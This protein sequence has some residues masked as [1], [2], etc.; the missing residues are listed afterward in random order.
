MPLKDRLIQIANAVLPQGAQIA[1][2][3]GDQVALRESAGATI[4]ADEENWRPLSERP[5][6]DLTPM[7]QYRMQRTAVY[8]WEQNLLGNRLVELPLAYMLA[9][10]VKLQ[11][12][13]PENQKLLDS[14]WNDPINDMDL[15]LA[16]KVRELTLFGEQCYPAFVND[17]D[18]FVRIGYLDPQLI[19][20]V[21][22]DPDNPEQPIGI[23]TMRNRKGVSRR[24][25]VIINGPEEVFTQ[26]TQA[27][28]DTFADGEAFYF[29]INDLS[30]GT[31]GRSDLLAQADWLD[32]YDQFLFGEMDRQK[33]LRAFIWDVTLK[34]ADAGQV[35]ARAAEITAPS[36]NSV[37]VHNDSE[38]WSAEAPSLNAGDTS[39]AARLLRNHVLG[40][41][42]MPETWYGGGG[43][44]N[45]ATAGEMN[46][47]TFKIYTMRQTTLKN[48]LVSI[49]RYVLL[50]GRQSD[51]AIDWA[52][53]KFKVRAVFPELA[54]RDATKYAAALQNVAA[55]CVVAINAKLISR[56][57]AVKVIVTVAASLGVEADPDEVLK[58]AT[59]EA[60]KEAEGDVFT[61]PAPAGEPAPGEPAAG[62]AAAG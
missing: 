37:R 54:V 10:G 53:P 43:N 13:D 45:R 57:F 7:T 22:M 18:G 5:I 28:R 1:L 50:R 16:K 40:G 56:A 49:G 19:Q 59:Q 25:K 3:S 44:V 48:M 62:D 24:Y 33:F 14:F 32:G 26:R 29:R 42:T 47:P 51:K 34:N 46:E 15:K 23:V 17:G 36:P 55:G 58:E 38:T 8:L 20:T 9:E 30:S 2:R 6:R 4:D 35:K 21:V 61:T 12:D 11:C 31:R 60:S 52:D 41:A 27:I 39:E